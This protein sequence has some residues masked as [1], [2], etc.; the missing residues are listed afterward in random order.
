MTKRTELSVNVPRSNQRWHRPRKAGTAPIVFAALIARQ[1]GPPI[2]GHVCE[3]QRRQAVRP[4]VVRVFN[5]HCVGQLQTDAYARAQTAVR[6][7]Q[8]DDAAEDQSGGT[9]AG[10]DVHQVQ[11]YEGT[12]TDARAAEQELQRAFRGEPCKNPMVVPGWVST[13]ASARASVNGRLVRLARHSV[14]T[15]VVSTRA[16]NATALHRQREQVGDQTI[17]S[18]NIDLSTRSLDTAS[19]KVLVKL[20]VP[21]WQQR[22]EAHHDATC[23]RLKGP[24]SVNTVSGAGWSRSSTVLCFKK[25]CLSVLVLVCSLAKKWLQ[26]TR[27]LLIFAPNLNQN[28]TKYTLSSRIHM[29]SNTMCVI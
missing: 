18:T 16:R 28:C 22:R 21:M 1:I 26:K 15:A 13:P 8:G 29:Q 24:A 23:C 7:E 19:T 27:A 20:L 17:P 5:K 4:R 11:N 12:V 9:L 2:R 10:G 3:A 25:K 14:S 6:T